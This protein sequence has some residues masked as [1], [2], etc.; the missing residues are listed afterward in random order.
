MRIRVA[1]LDELARAV[2]PHHQERRVVR[3]A[4]GLLHVVRDDDDGVLLRQLPH[5]VFDLQRGDRVERAARLVH[6]D[7]VGLDG[8][9]AR[10]AQALLLPAGEREPLWLSLSFTSSHSA[11]ARK[12]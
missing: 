11:A 10:D 4:R 12:R 3:D 7:H 2:R 1:I 9:R 8:E 6:Q 5:Q